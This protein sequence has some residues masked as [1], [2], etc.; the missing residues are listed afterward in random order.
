[1]TDDPRGQLHGWEK[2]VER[3]EAIR[4]YPKIRILVP[5]Q[6]G[7]KF[8]AKLD[9]PSDGVLAAGAT[10]RNTLVFRRVETNVQR[11]Y[12]AKR[13]FGDA[14]CWCF[15]FLGQ[16]VGDISV[17]ISG[18]WYLLPGIEALP[19][20]IFYSAHVYLPCSCRC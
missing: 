5:D 3:L 16:L 9:F 14:L 4:G 13:F 7:R 15:P 18:V 20:S 12:G 2:D 17:Q 11:R 8:P 10:R 1:M 19:L 6:G